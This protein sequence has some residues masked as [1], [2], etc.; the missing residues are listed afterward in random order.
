[1]L[2]MLQTPRI[3]DILNEMNHKCKLLHSLD[4][5]QNCIKVSGTQPGF[6]YCRLKNKYGL[7]QPLAIA[8]GNPL[9]II[10]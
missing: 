4:P 10:V 9:T 5:A 3:A 7:Q 8:T 1:M 2:A 6:H